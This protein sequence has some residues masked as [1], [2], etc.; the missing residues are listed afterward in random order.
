[1]S[2]TPWW[3]DP[4]YMVASATALIVAV[5][6]GVFALIANGPGAPA[7]RSPT[8]ASPPPGR[9]LTIYSSLPKRNAVGAEDTQTTNMERAM[10]LA[11]KEVGGEAGGHTVRYVSL[12]ATTAAGMSTT[13]R[14]E[15]NARRAAQDEDTAVYIGDRTS[16]A[17]A[18]SIPILSRAKIPQISPASTRVGLTVKDATGDA[19]EPD[20]Y[21]PTHFRNFVRIIPNDI[22]QAAALMTL[23]RQDG[24]ERLAMINDGGAYGAGLSN[25]MALLQRP[26][27]IFRQVVGPNATTYVST[28]L[29]RSAH[30]QRADCF[31]YVGNN[32]PNT[33]DVFQTF[34]TLLPRAKLYGTDALAAVSFRDPTVGGESAWWAG[35]V[36]LMVPPRDLARYDTFLRAYA[37]EYPNAKTPDPYAIYAYEAM[38]LALDAIGKSG[39]DTRKD[40]RDELFATKRRESVLGTY[41]IDDNGDTSLIDYDVARIRGDTLGRPVR[42][43]KQE[44][45]RRAT[46]LLRGRAEEAAA[47]TP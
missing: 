16:G 36:R 13:Q 42:E 27:R 9:P 1:M 38:R 24:C 30:R 46:N 45:L 20:K 41:S 19:D 29:A 6:G 21:Y 14:I 22:V 7:P 43:V 33:F 28:A 32:N 12:D 47:G 31:V 34:A 4:R 39:P 23:M 10:R 35:R 18:T 3:K 2:A 11:L 5:I 40:I 15:Q 25:N 44:M 37:K 26:K 8:A 17:S